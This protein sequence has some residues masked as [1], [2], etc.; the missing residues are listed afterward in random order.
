MPFENFTDQRAILRRRDLSPTEKLVALVALSFRNASS[1]RCDPPVESDDPSAD[2]I[3]GLSSFSRPCVSKALASLEAKGVIKR[4]A[5]SARPAQIVFTLKARNDVTRNEVTRNDV[6]PYPKR[7]YGLP[8][9]TL[10]LTDKYREEQ[11]ISVA[12]AC[13]CAHDERAEPD[14]SAMC[15]TLDDIPADVF[16]LDPDISD[17]PAQAPVVDKEKKPK[18]A[19]ETRGK[20]LDVDTL[21]EAWAQVAKQIQ[22]EVD[23]FKVFEDFKDYW[24]ARAGEGARKVDWVAT[25]RNWLRRMRPDDVRRYSR[26]VPQTKE[27]NFKSEKSW[28]QFQAERLRKEAEGEKIFTRLIS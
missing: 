16:G 19:K 17:P 13:A 27:A 4:T 25:W 9:T 26:F 1:G 23:P 15:P 5:R 6:T 3:C 11:I 8:V 22:P 18:Q 12:P 21:P 14:D 28:A 10:P 7:G 2:T 20:R 24:T